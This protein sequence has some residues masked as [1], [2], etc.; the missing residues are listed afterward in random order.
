MSNTSQI[1]VLCFR[2]ESC[3]STATVYIWRIKQH[4]LKGGAG[5]AYEILLECLFYS[6]FLFYKDRI[7]RCVQQKY[8]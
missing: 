4:P 6:C 3:L 7:E 5:I 2:I 8:S 1:K